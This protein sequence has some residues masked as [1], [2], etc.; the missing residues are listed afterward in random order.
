MLCVTLRRKSPGSPTQSTTHLY[1]GFHLRPPACQLERTRT[2]KRAQ[3]YFR[4]AKH[5]AIHLISFN[6]PALIRHANQ[7]NKASLFHM[8]VCIHGNLPRND[9]MREGSE[10]QAFSPRHRS[11][12]RMID[13]K[14]ANRLALIA[15]QHIDL[16]F[17]Q[18][19]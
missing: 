15:F 5:R 11:L 18:R 10:L 9:P 1:R 14:T 19:L 2:E 6:P 7:R 17:I 8:I 16:P 3:S 13:D 4:N 12:A